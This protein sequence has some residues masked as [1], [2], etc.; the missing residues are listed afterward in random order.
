MCIRHH[1]ASGA[2]TAFP[3]GA[4]FVD[5]LGFDFCDEREARSVNC[6]ERPLGRVLYFIFKMIR[7][8][9]LLKTVCA[10]YILQ[11]LRCVTEHHYLIPS[12]ARTQR[13][14][15]QSYCAIMVAKLRRCTPRLGHGKWWRH[16]MA[17]RWTGSTLPSPS[18][19]GTFSDVHL[20][21]AAPP[22]GPR[23]GVDSGSAVARG[24]RADAPGN[25]DLTYAFLGSR[26]RCNHHET[27]PPAWWTR[28]C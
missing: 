9:I 26:K 15:N 10:L 18:D 17:W 20:S 11:I 8:S 23:G 3:L 7:G 24:G 13:S 2:L 5:D 14:H 22:G 19:T 16:F 21:R 25:R 6:H 28:D 4:V 1:E 12:Q 27:R